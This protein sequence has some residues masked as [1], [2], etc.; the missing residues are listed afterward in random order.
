[1]IYDIFGAHFTP[2]YNEK[3]LAGLGRDL[4]KTGRLSEGGKRKC[5]EALARFSHI[6]AAR[7]LPAPLVG[8]TAALRVAEDAP[9]FV[10][11]VLA[12]TGLDISPISGE[13]EARLAA[14]GL[15]S[16]N[17]RRA[18]IGA[19]LGGAS[20][21]LMRIDASLK[22]DGAQVQ[23]VSLPLGP[24]D[25]IG[26]NLSD[27]TPQDYADRIP[28]LDAALS[29]VPG[30]LDGEDI[31]YLVGGAWRNLASVHQQRINYPMR[32]L[33]GYRLSATAAQNLAHWAWTD[34]MDDLLNWSGMRKA[35][36]ETLPYAGLM[37]ERLL[38]R[39]SPKSVVISMAGLREGLVWNTL[40]EQLKSRDAL[41]DGCRDFA[42]GF[43]QA[44]HFG[45]PLYRFLSP[46]LPALPCGFGEE[47]DARLLLAACHL[48]GLGKNLHPDHRAE[49]VFEDVLY[50]PV[51]GLSHAERVFLSLSLFR[52]Y[53]AKRK[54][55]VAGLI[56][57]LLIEAQR[58]TA[59]CIG[60]AIR[61]GIVV[62]G[63]TPSLL[64]D[65][66]L[67]VRGAELHLSCRPDRNAMITDQVHYRLAKLAKLLG[68]TPVTPT[69]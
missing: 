33:Q 34:G 54:P 22:K 17:D 45:P 49:L 57:E 20:L 30:Y 19:D 41:I 23:G 32:T 4:R 31:L 42:R 44:E 21:E 50:A 60:E 58:H 26:G 67:D 68:L 27:L 25:A 5:R 56:D 46:L 14:L 36:A 1:V 9:D 3:I 64:S 65:F 16:N 18:G 53:T 6:I 24:F 48:A 10:A 66:E 12:E 37:L 11:S 28:D 61:L 35:R 62:T 63:R 15:L 2:V 39:F 55:P 59:A 51:A 52:T 43:V 8:A 29:K 38:K 47:E 7:D 40:S 69:A 13:E